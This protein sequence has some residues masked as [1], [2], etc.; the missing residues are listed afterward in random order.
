MSVTYDAGA[1]SESRSAS[2][3][4][5]AAGQHG[6]FSRAQ[7]IE[8]GMSRKTIDRRVA[9]G[10][11]HRLHAGVY[12]LAGSRPTW[13]QSLIAAC[14][15]WG[16]GTVISHRAAGALWRLPGFDSRIVEL[17]APRRRERRHPAKMH[18]AMALPPADVTALDS[19]PVTT[20]E[21][22]LIDVASCVPADVVEEALDDALRRRLVSLPKLRWR[23]AELGGRGRVGGRALARLV[24]ARADPRSVPM[25]VFETRLFRVLRRARLP[26]PVAQYEVLTHSGK[27]VFD[28]AYADE[29]VAVEADGFRW[30]SSRRRWDHD[31]ERGNA[32]AMLGW[33]VIRVTWPQLHQRPEEIVGA[34]RA[35]LSG[36]S[37]TRTRNARP[38]D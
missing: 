5:L 17:T 10:E 3:A 27:A 24:E 32:V 33:T 23:L 28:F 18:V 37:E 21:R 11:F 34:V 1:A 7:A 36:R 31:R 2:L 38:R 13:R 4:R 35:V 25:S 6:V 19:I 20:P 30:H 22:T 8:C 15:I 9:S 26:I 14:F 12:R 29:K 16:K